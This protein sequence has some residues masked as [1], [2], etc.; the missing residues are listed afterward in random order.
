MRFWCARSRKRTCRSSPLNSLLKNPF[1][2][3]FNRRNVLPALPVPNLPSLDGPTALP[4][5]PH[6]RELATANGGGPLASTGAAGRRFIP[7]R[8]PFFPF[9]LH[10]ELATANGGRHTLKRVN[11][12]WGWP[13]LCAF[14]FCKGWGRV[15]VRAFPSSSSRACDRERFSPAPRVYLGWG[16]QGRERGRRELHRSLP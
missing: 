16:K 2:R 5:I 7:R 10:R 4:T 13:I 15:L 12:D 8:G 14:A 6:P 1:W 9:S 3:T 11:Q